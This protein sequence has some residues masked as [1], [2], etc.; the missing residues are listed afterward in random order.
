VGTTNAGPASCLYKTIIAE[1]SI[2]SQKFIAK[3]RSCAHRY[4]QLLSPVLEAS[5]LLAY[6][7]ELLHNCFQRSRSYYLFCLL[8]VTCK[9][10]VLR[11]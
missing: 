8:V 3:Y 11:S 2:L 6:A 7:K 1:Y 10:A 4:I 9:S 5:L